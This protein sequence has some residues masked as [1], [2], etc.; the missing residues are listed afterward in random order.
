MLLNGGGIGQIQDITKAFST[1]FAG[2]EADLRSLIEQLDEFIGHLDAQ[3]RDIIAAS[4]SLN[5]LAG[6]FAEQKPDG[7]QGA[8]APSPTH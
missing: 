3:T 5:N 8:Y 2:R 6:Q 4:E 1:A 7:G